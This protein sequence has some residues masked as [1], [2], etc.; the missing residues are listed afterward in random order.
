MSNGRRE[1]TE[2]G[3]G[4]AQRFLA[5]LTAVAGLMTQHLVMTADGERVVTAGTTVFKGLPLH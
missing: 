2:L 1:L 4:K 5:A 3:S